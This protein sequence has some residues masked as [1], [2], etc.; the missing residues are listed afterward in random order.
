MGYRLVAP[1]KRVRRPVFRY[2]SGG[3]GDEG[4]GGGLAEWED[5]FDDDSVDEFWTVDLGSPPGTVVESGGELCITPLVGSTVKIFQ[6]DFDQEFD[7][8]ARFRLR[9]LVDEDDI[10][11]GLMFA[12][13]IVPLGDRSIFMYLSY[14]DTDEWFIQVDMRHAGGADYGHYTEGGFSTEDLGDIT[15]RMRVSD[16]TPGGNLTVECYLSLDNGKN[17]TPIGGPETYDFDDISDLGFWIQDDS[18]RQMC[19]DY[20]LNTSTESC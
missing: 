19:I 5:C 11:T 20:F 1:S 3:N 13:S 17:W 14:W 16:W 9:D 4:E 15:L 2:C 18:G 6:S 7:I 8:K 12:N 10:T